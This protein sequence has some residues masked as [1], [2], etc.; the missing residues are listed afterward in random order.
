[1]GA[2][3]G[4][5]AFGDTADG[6][7]VARLNRV[8]STPTNIPPLTMGE[9]RSSVPPAGSPAGSPAVRSPDPLVAGPSRMP[10]DAQSISAPLPCPRY[11]PLSQQ[12]RS[13]EYCG[14]GWRSAGSSVSSI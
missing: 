11:G 9:S 14:T 2:Q 13:Y 7:P 4:G 5:D 3:T 1:M 12:G 8:S 10:A 6:S